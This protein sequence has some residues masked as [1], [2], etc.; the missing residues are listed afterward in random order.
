[1][2]EMPICGNKKLSHKKVMGAVL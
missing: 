1:M 2:S